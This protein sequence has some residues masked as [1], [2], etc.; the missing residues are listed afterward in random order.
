MPR[1]FYLFVLLPS[2][3]LLPGAIRKFR[4]NDKYY[5]LFML[6]P[7][8]LCVSFLWA[9]DENIQRDFLFHLRNLFCVF[10][11]VIGLWLIM[12]RKRRFVRNLLIFLFFTG[13]F[14]SVVSLVN[15]FYLYGLTVK[16]VMEG[17]FI[18][19][20]NKIGSIYSIHVC[21][22]IFFLFFPHKF[23]EINKAYILP[24][25]AIILSCSVIFLSQAVIPWLIIAVFIVG[26]LIKKWHW[27][28]ILSLF[29]VIISVG[30]GLLYY[31]DLFES[32]I[33][34]TRVQARIHLVRQAIEQMDGH[35][36]FG[37]GLVYKLP[38]INLFGNGI[39][40]HPHNIFVDCFRFGGLVGLTLVLG[41]FFLLIKIGVRLAKDSVEYG[42]I[43]FWFIAGV[44]VL[45]FYGQ[46]PLIRPGGYLWFFYWT[47]GLLLLVK[48]II[49]RDTMQGENL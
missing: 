30:L 28:K 16:N 43:L 3:L 14:T 36:L 1:I 19:N 38:L 15:Y 13:Y 9:A 24:A 45:S 17:Y 20:S 8:Y 5:I 40:P 6:F 42:F 25:T 34:M 7:I 46:Q 26:M 44:I 10:L 11:Y 21:L 31:F 47:P 48:W 27:F 4:F 37:I 2:L 29:F 22:S 35:Y 32:L 18:D 49:R 23:I 33:G 12:G 41:Q 39:N